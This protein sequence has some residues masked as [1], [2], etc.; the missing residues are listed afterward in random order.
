MLLIIIICLLSFLDQL[1]KY[2]ITVNIPYG[3]SIEIIDGFFYLTHHKNPG[4]A[5]SFLADYSWGIYILSAFSAVLLI[6]MLY[7]LFK[8]RKTAPFIFLLDIAILI[9]G[10]LGNLI[11]RIRLKGVIDYLMFDFGAF[12][13]PTFNLADSC[14]VVG[15]IGFI[16]LTFF[17]KNPFFT[18][19]A[20]QTTAK[21][22]ESTF[23]ILPEDEDE[24]KNEVVHDEQE[25]PV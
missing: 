6:V 22:E 25:E 23:S 20:E 3:E 5:F 4:A 17:H 19:D 24:E 2:L 13:F 7:I 16:L 9:A 12:I 10:N 21:S 18:D 8:F 14:V 15:A 1:F 11:D